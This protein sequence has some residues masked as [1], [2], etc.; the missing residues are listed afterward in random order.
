MVF[1]WDCCLKFTLQ[2][3]VDLQLDTAVKRKTI[4]QGRVI[5]IR[6]GG[7]HEDVNTPRHAF[8]PGFYH[9]HEGGVFTKPAERGV[10]ALPVKTVC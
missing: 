3:E 10:A 2:D 1:F 8:H 5:S 4:R 6:F 7:V 9:A